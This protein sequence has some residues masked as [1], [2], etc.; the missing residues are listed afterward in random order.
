MDEKD[1]GTKV[2]PVLTLPMGVG[3]DSH[4]NIRALQRLLQLLDSPELCD[5]IDGQPVSKAHLGDSSGYG[6]SPVETTNTVRKRFKVDLTGNHDKAFVELTEDHLLPQLKREDPLFGAFNDKAQ[7]ALEWQLHVYQ[8]AEMRG[9]TYYDYFRE[10]PRMVEVNGTL[11]V[12]GSPRKPITEYIRPNY[13]T[14]PDILRKI[15]EQVPKA[16]AVAHTHFSM[17]ILYDPKKGSNNR[18][19]W[20]WGPEVVSEGVLEELPDVV[21]S[22]DDLSEPIHA[23]VRVLAKSKLNGYKAVINFGSIGQP[24]DNCPLAKGGIITQEGYFFLRVPY[25]TY[26]AAADIIRVGLPPILGWRLID[27]DERNKKANG[28]VRTLYETD[29]AFQ[30]RFAQEMATRGVDYPL[31]QQYSSIKI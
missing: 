1:I 20:A 22:P 13:V 25:D 31:P 18:F 16:V 2:I 10:L 11:L 6:A 17:L 24:R 4:S 29:D 9:F 3:G 7:E 12:H 19:Y 15:F 26:G 14:M 23:N 5:V 8:R 28:G 21:F 30:K 27:G